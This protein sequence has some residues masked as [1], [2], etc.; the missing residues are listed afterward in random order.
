[1]FCW[2]SYACGAVCNAW[3]NGNNIGNA[4]RRI[5]SP[6]NLGDLSADRHQTLPH[7]R[8]RRRLPTK[9]P[10]FIKL[11]QKFGWPLPSKIWRPKKHQNFGAI[12]EN[13]VTWSRIPPDLN[14]I[15]SSENGV[16]N[17][18]HFHTCLPNLVNFGLQTA[19]NRTVVW[20]HPKSTF[21]Y[22]HISGLRGVALPLKISHGIEDDQRFLMDT[23][24]GW[25]SSQQTYSFVW[26]TT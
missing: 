6:P 10:T 7:V 16:A 13:F 17:C 22:A 4:R 24:R 12:S 14:K 9:S 20:T 1:M 5:F 11:G 18:D 8:R 3:Q 19:K 2:G 15:S 26:Y 21:S 23:L 25:V